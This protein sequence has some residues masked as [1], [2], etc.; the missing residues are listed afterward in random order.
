M[1][2]LRGGGD[3]LTTLAR[4][5]NGMTA[6]MWAAASS[7]G[8]AGC[9]R[10]LLDAGADKNITCNRVRVLYFHFRLLIFWFHVHAEIILRV[11][12]FEVT[13]IH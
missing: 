3:P 11:C 7:V 12:Y 5:Q 9:V 8:G 2:H 1:Y 6:L 10:L 4:A 13:L